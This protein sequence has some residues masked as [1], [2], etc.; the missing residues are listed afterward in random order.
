[1]IQLV[2]VVCW[3]PCPA[4]HLVELSPPSADAVDLATPPKSWHS[5]PFFTLSMSITRG[6]T[7]AMSLEKCCGSAAMACGTMQ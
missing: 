4:T 2:F 3:L 5:S 6:A 1:M 7:L